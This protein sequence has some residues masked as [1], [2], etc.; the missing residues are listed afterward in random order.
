MTSATETGAPPFPAESW[1][2]EAAF[3]QATSPEFIGVWTEGFRVKV[4]SLAFTHS[5]VR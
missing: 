5:F 2:R 3:A 4:A 1:A